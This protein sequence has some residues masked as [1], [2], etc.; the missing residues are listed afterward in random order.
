MRRGEVWWAD[1]DPPSGRR[2]VV[3]LSREAAYV[4]RDSIT[5]A[6]VTRTIRNIPSE[7]LLTAEDGMASECIVNCDN[8]L[9]VPKTILTGCIAQLTPEKIAE[10]EKAIKFALGLR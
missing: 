4:I 8:I 10:V 5:V 7:V 2:P 3:L 1:L 9:T 6:P